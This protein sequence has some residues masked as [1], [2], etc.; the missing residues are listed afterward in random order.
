MGEHLD[1]HDK[2]PRDLVKNSSCIKHRVDVTF[3]WLQYKLFRYTF[4]RFM[5]HYSFGLL[6]SKGVWYSAERCVPTVLS[7]HPVMSIRT[8]AQRTSSDCCADVLHHMIDSLFL[9]PIPVIGRSLMLVNIFRTALVVVLD[10]VMLKLP[11]IE[12]QRHVD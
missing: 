10:Y 12:H 7:C 6:F 2:T 11:S 9:W 8:I 1:A 4:W 5:R 3:W